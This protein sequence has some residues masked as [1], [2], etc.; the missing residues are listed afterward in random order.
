MKRYTSLGARLDATLNKTTGH[1]LSLSALPA[2]IPVH[3]FTSSAELSVLR[4]LFRRVKHYDEIFIEQ[5]PGRRKRPRET[6]AKKPWLQ[7]LD[8]VLCSVGPDDRVWGYRGDDLLESGDLKREEL[9]TLV[10]GDIAGVLIPRPGMWGDAKLA[11]IRDHWNGIRLE[12]LQACAERA[13]VLKH[14]P[15]VCVFAAGANKAHFVSQCLR[16]RDDEGKVVS[17][18]NHLII[19]D[20]LA[21]RLLK[22]L[23]GAQI[24]TARSRKSLRRGLGARLNHLSA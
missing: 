12:D 1:A 21:A 19:D 13:V 18:I 7:R 16:L 3:E 22:L 24:P 4:R 23:G 17:L 2:L 11:I 20:D 10:L 15:G 14:V 6:T 8:A 9:Q 5:V